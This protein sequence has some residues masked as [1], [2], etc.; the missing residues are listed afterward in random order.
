VESLQIL[1]ELQI[2]LVGAGR[3]LLR[4]PTKVFG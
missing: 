1:A 3:H 4:E 2:G